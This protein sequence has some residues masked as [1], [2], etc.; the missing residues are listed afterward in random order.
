MAKGAHM[1]DCHKVL[2]SKYR[3][4]RKNFLKNSPFTTIE[5]AVFVVKR[6]G[7]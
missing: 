1:Y 3:H 4:K 6:E 2:K 7:N 5:F